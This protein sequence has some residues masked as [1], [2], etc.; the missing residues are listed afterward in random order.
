MPAA[1]VAFLLVLAAAWVRPRPSLRSAAQ[2][3]GAPVTIALAWLVIPTAVLLAYS[4]VVQPIYLDRY[5]TFTVPAM[6]LLLGVCV[7][8]ITQNTLL[9]I[10]LIVL[11]FICALP[12]YLD[13]RDR[14]PKPGIDYSDAADLVK[15]HAGPGHCLLLDDTV[16]WEPGPIRAMVQSRPD[17]YASL[18]DVGAGR[19]AS[20]T[21]MM[22]SENLP[23]DAVLDR[24]AT[25]KV[26]WTLSQRDATL[27]AHEVGEA[28]PPG[29]R[30]GQY[31]AFFR[32]AQ[33]GFRLVER[34]QFNLSQVT[35][36]VR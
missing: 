32:P 11:L 8:R 31:P 25:C 2:P 21:G 14:Y 33:M 18:T 15:A 9:A 7:R 29:P 20:E 30:F 6:A 23:P 22:W 36:A 3:P 4:A 28:L 35:R 13:Q 26:I 12:N 10:G 19:S 16:S 24:L 17:A 27:P 34:W 5:L 1:V